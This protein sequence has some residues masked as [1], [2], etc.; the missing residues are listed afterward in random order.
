[1]SLRAMADL[2]AWRDLP[3]ELQPEVESGQPVTRRTTVVAPG[4]GV[5]GG[6]KSTLGIAGS[7]L[8]SA[9]PSEVLAPYT[10]AVGIIVANAKTADRLVALRWWTFGV[11]LAFVAATLVADSFRG[12]AAAR[13]A[14]QAMPDD[15]SK[16]SAQQSLDNHRRLPLPELAASA[17][18]FIAWGLAMPGNPLEPM[19]SASQRQLTTALIT[20]GGGAMIALLSPVLDQ[21]SRPMRA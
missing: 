7:S 5:A 4:P 6:L 11:G 17:L 12:K 2:A 1:M 13:T 10:A 21:K 16:T 14:V 18:A 8:T 9:I 3:A 15:D 20:V 19:I